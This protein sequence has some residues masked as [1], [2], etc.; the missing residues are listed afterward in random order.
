L[1]DD[2]GFATMVR[3]AGYGDH[4]EATVDHDIRVRG[5]VTLTASGGSNA[6]THAQ[7]ESDGGR[8][9]VACGAL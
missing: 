7:E 3:L 8:A 1:V 2:L 9:A 5:R 4:L 6:L